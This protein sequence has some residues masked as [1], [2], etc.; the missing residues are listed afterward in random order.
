MSPDVRPA[1][2]PGDVCWLGWVEF[3]LTDSAQCPDKHQHCL[4]IQAAAAGVHL[5]NGTC[6]RTNSPC[7]LQK[8][9]TDVKKRVVEHKCGCQEEGQACGSMQLIARQVLISLFGPE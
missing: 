1:V 4:A 6:T 2:L 5:I 8:T 9:N 7:C 3:L